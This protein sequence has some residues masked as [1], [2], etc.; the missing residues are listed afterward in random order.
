MA[1]TGIAV[2]LSSVFV[3]K[4][5]PFQYCTSIG[6]GRAISCDPFEFASLRRP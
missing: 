4:P 3:M 5:V 2:Q 1:P 6:I